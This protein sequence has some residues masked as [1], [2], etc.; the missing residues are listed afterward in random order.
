[1]KKL[2]RFISTA[3]CMAMPAGYAY[4][5]STTFAGNTSS[6]WS[7]GMVADTVIYG[8][9]TSTLCVWPMRGGQ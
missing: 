7:V 2:F 4:W 3:F 5:S 9:K 6:G 1:M 8:G